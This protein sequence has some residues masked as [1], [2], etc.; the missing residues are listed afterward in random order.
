MP[1]L[2]TFEKYVASRYAPLT[3]DIEVADGQLNVHFDSEDVYACALQALVVFPTA[4]KDAGDAF[5]DDLLTVQKEEF[6][7]EYV[8]AIYEPSTGG[9]S[10]AAGAE[11]SG[12]GPQQFDLFS[13]HPETFVRG[14][15][16]MAADDAN[17][18]ATEL[19]TTLAAGETTSLT[20]SMHLKDTVSIKTGGAIASLAVEGAEFN[21]GVDLA[22]FTVRN[23][24]MRLT[25]G[26][27]TAQPLLL[28][29]LELPLELTAGASRRFWLQ[30]EARGIAGCYTGNVSIVFAS[31]ATLTI[32]LAVEVE[33]VKLEQI[34]PEI[35]VGFLGLTPMVPSTPFPESSEILAQ[36]GAAASIEFLHKMG[37]TG[38]T[39]GLGGPS[40]KGYDNS[41]NAVVDFANADATM[42]LVNQHWPAGKDHPML[43]SYAGMSLGGVSHTTSTWN[44][45]SLADVHGK[46]YAT[47]LHDVLAAIQA[48]AELP[49]SK[50]RPIFH[51]LGDEPSDETSLRVLEVA[52]AFKNT[53]VSPPPLTSVFTSITSNTSI[54]VQFADHVD[55][56]ILNHHTE[57][58]IRA[59]QARNPNVK[60]MLYNQASRYRVGFYTWRLMELGGLGHYQFMLSSPGADPYYALD[61][62][63]DDYCSLFLRRDGSVRG[64]VG[65]GSTEQLRAALF[66]LRY[67]LTLE[68][69]IAAASATIAAAASPDAA[70]V[71]AL[72]AATQLKSKLQTLMP[73]GRLGHGNDAPEPSTAALDGFRRE[74]SKAVLR[75][76]GGASGRERREESTCSA[77]NTR[78]AVFTPSDC[79]RYDCFSDSK[80]RQRGQRFYAVPEE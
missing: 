46:P 8:Q 51:N 61:A 70:L 50:W 79:G 2:N 77:D 52:A 48:H 16:K 9:G 14:F 66:D 34:P 62:R 20:F 26:V 7:N 56:V 73:I 39:G 54:K 75:L 47:A 28:D 63:E 64:T 43:N 4:A 78:S 1:G 41:G 17:L 65:S 60:W 29:P 25:E 11:S 35:E 67:A 68:A 6:D 24:I 37:V 23:K 58:S 12:K 21:A 33:D 13:R 10:V 15:D 18:W 40:F 19:I 38:I 45:A 59:L 49:N 31:G 71:E 74:I 27:Y 22:I 55:L 80:Q 72:A 36:Q 30:L 3:F 76:H 53:G 44:S 42:E 5:L 32:P 69:A 57:D